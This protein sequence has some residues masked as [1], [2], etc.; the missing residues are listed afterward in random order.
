M[1]RFY[2]PPECAAALT[3]EELT[4]E[5]PQAR[6]MALVVR[7]GTGE[8]VEFFD[9]RGLVLQ[10]RLQQVGHNRIR[11]LVTAR[12]QEIRPSLP[13][14]VLA[15]ALL[16]GKKMDLLVQ[17]ANELGVHAMQPLVSRFCDRHGTSDAV[18][19]RWQRIVVESCKQCRRAVPMALGPV[20]PPPPLIEADFSWAA[21]RLVAH[22]AD[23]KNAEKEGERPS[24]LCAE[25][26]QGGAEPICLVI[27]PEGGLHRDELA[28]LQAQG[29]RSFSLGPRILRAET[30]ALAAMAIIQHLSGALRPQI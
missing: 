17:K 30:A 28:L 29:F 1:R 13:R 20:L 3:G 4:V 8:R 5:G 2:L 7:L 27:G 21:L 25:M 26:L 24:G 23:T 22:A 19:A 16:Q 12:H 18:L 10:A 9:G 11:A 15:Q 14:L 6:H